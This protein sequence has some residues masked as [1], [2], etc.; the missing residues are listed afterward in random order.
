MPICETAVTCMVCVLAFLIN[1]YH[2][3]IVSKGVCLS[4]GK[5]C[6]FR[7]ISKLIFSS[8]SVIGMNALPATSRISD[9]SSVSTISIGK[10]ILHVLTSD[11]IT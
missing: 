10:I 8:H 9:L 1:F 7:S 5:S 2:T 4:L 11:E 6:I 3:L